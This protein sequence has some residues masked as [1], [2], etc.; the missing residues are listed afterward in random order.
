MPI[1]LTITKR[2]PT[3]VTYHYTDPRTGRLVRSSVGHKF[4]NQWIN[5]GGAVVVADK[6]K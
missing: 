6:S 3:R 5:N 4:F 1:R 2:S